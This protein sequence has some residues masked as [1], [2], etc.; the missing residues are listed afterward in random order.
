M[1]QNYAKEYQK[2]KIKN[3]KTQY[4]YNNIKIKEKENIILFY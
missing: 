4:V 2:L 1:V 3:A